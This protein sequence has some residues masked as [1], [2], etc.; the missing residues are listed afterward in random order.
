MGLGESSGAWLKFGQGKGLYG[1]EGVLGGV[2]WWLR[3]LEE[4]WG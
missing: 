2:A 3:S 4:A 1:L